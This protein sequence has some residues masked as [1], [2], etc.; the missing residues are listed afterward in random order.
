MAFTRGPKN[1]SGGPNAPRLSNGNIDWKR[2]LIDHLQPIIADQ[3]APNTN[4]GLMYILESKGVL[5]KSDYDGL[6]DHLVKW[7]QDGE[8]N[9]D[10]VADGSGRGIMNDFSDYEDPT[11]W[12]ESLC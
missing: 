12:I 1:N 3:I 10:D 5:K 7:R 6:T 9:W 2:V 4:R 8:I 11:S